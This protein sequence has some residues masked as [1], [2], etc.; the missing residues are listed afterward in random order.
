MTHECFIKLLNRKHDQFTLHELMSLK[1]YTDTDEYQSS[2]RKA[3]WSQDKQTKQS[4]YH[5][6]L[7]LYK[8]ALYHAKPIPAETNHDPCPVYH[9]IFLHYLLQCNVLRLSH[10]ILRIE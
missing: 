2:L 1:M 3:F 4:F 8:T 6:A 5:W 9:G 7:Q 10:Q